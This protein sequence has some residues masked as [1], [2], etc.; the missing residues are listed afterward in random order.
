MSGEI[1]RKLALLL[2]PDR[3]EHP[4]ATNFCQMYNSAI[5]ILRNNN[6]AGG[7]KCHAKTHKRHIKTNKRNKR[8]RKTHKRYKSRKNY[9]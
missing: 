5:E 3:C 1:R 7:R 2:H 6:L 9:R 8:H 4:S